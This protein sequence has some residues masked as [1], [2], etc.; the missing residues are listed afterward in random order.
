MFPPPNDS[1][2]ITNGLLMENYLEKHPKKLIS[3]KYE[4][5]CALQGAGQ[6]MAI[7]AGLPSLLSDSGNCVS[8]FR[9]TKSPPP[10]MHPPRPTV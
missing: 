1:E 4:P 3:I 2:S 5:A 8:D 10:L 9:L 6:A 7:A